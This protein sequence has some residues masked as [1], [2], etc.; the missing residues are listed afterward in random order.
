MSERASVLTSHRVTLYQRMRDLLRAERHKR[1]QDKHRYD[2]G[3]MA[4]PSQSAPAG[5][6]R[7]WLIIA[8][9]GFGKTRTG[10]ETIRS[11]VESGCAKRL[12]LLGA[13]MDDVRKVMVEGESGLLQVCPPWNRPTFYPSR[14]MLEWP[15]GAVAT[16]YSGHNYEKLR[17]PQ[18]D[19]AWVDELAKFDDPEAAWDQLMMGLRL[20]ETP[21]VVVTTTPKP[22]PFLR[23]LCTLPGAVVSRGSTF[24]NKKNLSSSYLEAMKQR[25]EGTKLGKQELEGQFVAAEENAL[26][27]YDLLKKCRWPEGKPLP[28]FVSCLVGVDPSVTSGE[29][30]DETGIVVVG[31]DAHGVLYVL[32]DISGRMDA[33]TWARRAIDAYRRHEADAIV[34]EVNNG[35]DLVARVI[36]DVDET[37]LVHAVRALRGKWMRAQPV[38]ALYA[39]ARVFHAGDMAALEQQMITYTPQASSSPDRL[40]ALVWAVSEMIHPSHKAPSASPGPKIWSLG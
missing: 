14:G 5:D 32:E 13:N 12:C 15:S 33:L 39:Q 30:S 20:G 19:G 28:T 27:S 37:V 34:A 10:A 6:W 8:G 23:R 16:L 26:W 25:Y 11:W 22:S 4:R 2:W 17:G 7:L 24:E 9:R 31:K 38:A 21:R 1:H 18:F 29:S 40:D 35:G 36:H 3:R